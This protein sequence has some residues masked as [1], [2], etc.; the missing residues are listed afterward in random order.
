LGWHDKQTFP[1]LFQ[2]YKLDLLP[3]KTKIIGY[4]RSDMDNDKFMEQVAGGL[5]GENEKKVEEFKKLAKYVRGA[6]DEDEAFQV[7]LT[8]FEGL[9]WEDYWCA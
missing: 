6:Y 7:S 4:A 9:G 2:L 3:S 1:S 5:E 8:W